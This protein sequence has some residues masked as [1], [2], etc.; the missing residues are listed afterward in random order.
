MMMFL[1][2]GTSYD[3]WLKAFDVQAR[4]FHWPHEWFTSLQLLDQT[5]LPD[6]QAY[7]SRLT[8]SGITEAQYADIQNVW[9]EQG[10][11]MHEQSVVQFCDEWFKH[12]I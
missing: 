9:E 3:G 7:Q 1:A 11:Y 8:G 10:M 12:I 4:K 5:Y 2:A 6:I